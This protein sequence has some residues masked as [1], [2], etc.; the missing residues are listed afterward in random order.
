M[1][2]SI[3]C[4][5]DYWSCYNT[6]SCYMCFD[7]CVTHLKILNY[8]A[9]ITIESRGVTIRGGS[10]VSSIEKNDDGK[11]R[12]HLD[13][14]GTDETG[15]VE[16]C[17]AVVLAV[18][19]VAAG[20]IASLSPAL[21]TLEATKDFD[22]LR[23]VTCVAVRLFLKP[24]SSVTSNLNGGSH[25]KTQLPPDIANSMSDSPIIVC[26]AGI[27]GIKELEETGFCIYDLQRMHDEFSVDYYSNNVD[28]SDQVA[29]MEVDFYRADSFVNLDN[30]EIANL[31]LEAVSAALGT[32]KIDASSI[33][34]STVLR[35]R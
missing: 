3:G 34:D 16:E 29:V 10:R 35:A 15:A 33:V 13:P 20:R 31:A 26:G 12:V 17:D 1:A 2:I 18:G 23:G 14:I 11:F 24:H 30:G 5:S 21:S 32:A 25:G 6:D 9:Q 28:Q 4:V 19:A 27:G 22:K 7:H 8:S